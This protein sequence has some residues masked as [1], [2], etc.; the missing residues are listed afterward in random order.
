MGVGLTFVLV[1]LLLDTKQ[2]LPSQKPFM[3]GSA[4]LHREE[5]K[6]EGDGTDS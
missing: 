2:F 1:G 4:F 5:L 3:I 6:A